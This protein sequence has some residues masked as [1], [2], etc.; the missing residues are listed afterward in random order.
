MNRRAVITRLLTCGLAACVL[1]VVSMYNY[2]SWSQIAHYTAKTIYEARQPLEWIQY[3]Q[4]VCLE[5][6]GQPCSDLAE[7][8]ATVAD[9]QDESGR[10]KV[11]RQLE[12]PDQ[13]PNRSSPYTYT[14]EAVNTEAFEAR[15]THYSGEDIWR[16]AAEGE[17]SAVTQSDE[18]K[19]YPH[20]GV[21]RWATLILFVVYLGLLAESAAFTWRHATSRTKRVASVVAVFGLGL[22]GPP[23]AFGVLNTLAGWLLS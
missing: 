18:R 21:A 9:D 4:T 10:S 7:L 19:G 2:A 15:A 6:K 13:A 14:L 16:I 5:T 22:F 12:Y 17:V 20:D 3:A 8:V 1:C 11:E 23:F